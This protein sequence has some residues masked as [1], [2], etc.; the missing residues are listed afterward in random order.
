[1]RTN[2]RTSKDAALSGETTSPSE[3]RC[4]DEQKKAEVILLFRLLM[5][6]PPA[7]HDFRTC[8]I[9]KRY[10]ITEI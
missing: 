3:E 9:C 4:K 5:R 6:Q 8:P 7:N 2:N 10:G 1:M